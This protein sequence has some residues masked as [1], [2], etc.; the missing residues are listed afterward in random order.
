[1]SF[2]VKPLTVQWFFGLCVEILTTELSKSLLPDLLEGLGIFVH[3]H[4]LDLF[5]QH[6]VLCRLLC[7]GAVPILS[8][9]FVLGG[10][11]LLVC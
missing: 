9:L 5:C 7:V 3:L 6:I 2:A 1:M 4:G 8:N 10:L 11:Q